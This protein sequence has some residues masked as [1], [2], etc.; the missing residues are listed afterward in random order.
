VFKAAGL[1]IE[2]SAQ[3]LKEIWSKLALNVATL[4]TSSTIKLTAEKLPNTTEMQ[5]LMRALLLEVVSV[6]QL[7]GIALDFAER[8]NAIT[9]LLGKL[10]PNTKSSMLQ[11][12][13]NR[14]RTEIDVMCGA[15][16]EAGQ[17][18]DSPRRTTTRCFGWSNRSKLITPLDHAFAQ[19]PLLRCRAYELI[20]SCG[21]HILVDPFLDDCPCNLVK[22]D[23]LERVDLVVVSHAAMDHLG[24]TEKIARKHGCPVICGGEVKAY[25]MRREFPANKFARRPGASRCASPA[26]MCSPSSAIT[27]RRSR[28]PTAR[29]PAAYRW[30]SSS[31]WTTASDSTIT[32]TRRSSRT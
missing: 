13:E 18:L 17:R 6:A 28:C 5:S 16:V 25:L 8:W 10:A 12:V 11:D 20:D 26:S 4:P 21:Q 31:T 30:L 19:T 24:D 27:G 1:D 29:S 15:I 3:V 23:H 9:G 2:A 14:R 22:S 7:Q 32:A